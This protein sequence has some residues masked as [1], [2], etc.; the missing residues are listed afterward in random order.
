MYFQCISDQTGNHYIHAFM[1]IRKFFILDYMTA[2]K[3]GILD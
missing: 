1:N 2:K 3:S